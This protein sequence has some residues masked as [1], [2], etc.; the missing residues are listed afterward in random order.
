MRTDH[1]DDHLPHVHIW[2]DQP[3]FVWK[4]LSP[5]AAMRAAGNGMKLL[6]V[7]YSD[8][9]C[10]LLLVVHCLSQWLSNLGLSCIVDHASRCDRNCPTLWPLS[11]L[12]QIQRRWRGKLLGVSSVSPLW[13]QLCNFVGSASV[14][15][16]TKLHY[17]PTW[18]RRYKLAIKLD[19]SVQCSLS[20][21][22]T[23]LTIKCM[24][25]WKYS[26]I[27]I[28]VHICECVS[29]IMNSWPIACDSQYLY[30]SSKQRVM[31]VSV[32]SLWLYAIAL[33]NTSQRKISEV[34]N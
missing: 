1:H 26:V 2:R 23:L 28:T 27:E 11:R 6:S 30:M 12:W 17:W 18:I 19:N 34:N 32:V 16:S 29:I 21:L 25:C 15:K 33:F 13:P 5:T 8:K 20:V 9:K 31:G 14:T 22:A 10:I 3:T 24:T 4:P 7:R